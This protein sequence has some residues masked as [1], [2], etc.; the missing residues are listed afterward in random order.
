MKSLNIILLVAIFILG[1]S[2]VTTYLKLRQI[3]KGLPG[4]TLVADSTGTLTYSYGN[5]GIYSGSGVV[6]VGTLATI[7]ESPDNTSADF[8]VGNFPNWPL[9]NLTSTERGFFYGKEAH[10]G[11]GI[12][13]GTPAGTSYIDL[14]GAN[15]ELLTTNN[16][17]RGAFITLSKD[18]YLATS[19]Y[20]EDS[21]VTFDVTAYSID[22]TT[23]GGNV[24]KIFMGT[25]D[26]NGVITANSGC[27]YLRSGGGV[28]SSFYVKETD[29]VNTG[30][31]AK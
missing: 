3:E 22:M 10:G 5:N 2:Q 4:Q 9:F 20:D 13:Y 26:P 21:Y 19:A 25:G 6:P 27:I 8:A 29:N 1:T 11:T 23:N 7:S 17:T 16:T 18:G 30:W 31:T 24:F 12:V 28:G 14:K 15:M